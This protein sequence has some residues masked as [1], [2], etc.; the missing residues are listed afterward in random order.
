VNHNL[1][2]LD[3]ENKQAGSYIDRILRGTVLYPRFHRAC[4]VD[5]HNKTWHGRQWQQRS[6]RLSWKYSEAYTANIIIL[7]FFTSYSPSA[8]HLWISSAIIFPG[9]N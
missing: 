8:R 7:F 6:S 9:G 5:E 1:G 4:A 3:G 2:D